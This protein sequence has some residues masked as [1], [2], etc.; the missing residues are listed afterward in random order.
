MH[1][2][3][4]RPAHNGDKILVLRSY[5]P[6]VV[7]MLYDAVPGNDHCNGRVAYIGP[8]DLCPDLKECLHLDDVRAALAGDVPDASIPKPTEPPA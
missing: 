4:G 2:R 3:N 5:G 6:P 8:G 7:G 1:Y